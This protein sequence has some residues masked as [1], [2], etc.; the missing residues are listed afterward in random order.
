M[1]STFTF[2]HQYGITAINNTD[3]RIS[4]SIV[5]IQFLDGSHPIPDIHYQEI[6]ELV[7]SFAKTLSRDGH[8]VNNVLVS[9]SGFWNQS[10]NYLTT[11]IK[12]IKLHQ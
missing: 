8:L 11:L 10:N 7:R 12:D 3:V 5:S 2:N 4:K 6:E 1:E 9:G